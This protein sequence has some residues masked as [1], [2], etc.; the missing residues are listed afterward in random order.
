MIEQEELQTIIPHKGKMLLLSRVIEYN[1]NDHSI[2]AE[3]DVVKDC[4]F[5]D[6]AIDGVPVWVGFEFM[7]QAI[8]ALSG[9]RSREKGEKPKIGFILSVPAMRMEIPLF[10]AGSPV[11]V[12]VKETDCTD[13]IYSFDGAAFWEGKK[14]MEGKLM[15]IEVSDER[16]N[17][18]TGG[19]YLR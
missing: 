2:R 12:R 19:V 7:A 18:L 16:F 11:E 5:Y 8:S 6:P 10:K 4:I 15:V 3:Y 13:M 1:S 17:E 9:I 14:V